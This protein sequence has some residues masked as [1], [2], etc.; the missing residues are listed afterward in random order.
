MTIRT[1]QLFYIGEATGSKIHTRELE[2]ETDGRMRTL[3]LSLKQY[4]V[5]F[6]QFYEKGTMRAMVGLQG[7]HTINAFWC[8]NVS[9][10]VELKS[11]CPWCFKLGS[12]RETIATHLREV[13]YHLAIAY[14]IC[15]AFASMSAQAMLEHH[16][17]CEVKSHK[18]KSKATDQ[19]KTS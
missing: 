12:N 5:Q 17:G 18:K 7:L 19:E 11:F 1:D 14:D 3:V 2:V 6:Y 16:M 4:H 8:S 9:S 13:H 10:R 15:K